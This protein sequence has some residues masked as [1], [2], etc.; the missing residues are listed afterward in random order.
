M[1]FR[2]KISEVP[3]RDYMSVDSAVDPR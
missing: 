3:W 1:L 2:F